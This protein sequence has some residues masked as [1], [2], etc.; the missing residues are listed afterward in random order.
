MIALHHYHFE[1]V[2]QVPLPLEQ[3]YAVLD[4]V[5]SYAAWWPQIR[6]C[7]PLDGDR[8]RLGIRSLLPVTLDVVLTGQV[9]DLD[10]G[11]LRV[12]LSE[13]L[14][15]Y[16]QWQLSWQGDTTTAARWTQDVHLTHEKLQRLPI[17]SH[18]L[19]RLNHAHMMRSGEAGLRRWLERRPVTA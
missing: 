10:Q 1:H 2:W 8:R 7:Q 4:D 15:G 5:D 6:S 19:L 13:D 9:G 11:V 12:G 16:A 14:E 18:R 17:T 3:A